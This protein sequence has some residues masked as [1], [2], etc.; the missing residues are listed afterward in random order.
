MDPRFELDPQALGISPPVPAPKT[1]AKTIKRP[2]RAVTESAAVSGGAK[3]TVHVVKSG[4]NLFRILMRDYGLTNEEAESFIEE[5]RHENNIYD[6]KRLKIGQKIIIPPI[7]RKADGT[8]KVQAAQR[9]ADIAP[10][11]AGQPFHLESPVAPLSE[12][13]AAVRMKQAWDTL[14]PPVKGSQDPIAIQS[15]TFSLSL[16]PARF[17]VYA[18]MN[19]RRILIDQHA[20]IP[21]LVSSLITEKDPSVRIVSE[22][23]A[24]GRHFIAAL[25]ESAGFYSVEENFTMEFGTDPKL[26]VQSDFKIEK[27]PESLIRHDVVLI[28]SGRVSYPPALSDFLKKEGFSVF[29]PFGSPGALRVDLPRQVFQITSKHQTDIVDAILSSLSVVS[30]KDRRLDVFAADNNGI[31]LSVKAERYFEQGGQST[32]VTRFDGDP[33]A[34]TLF[35]IL[36]ARGFQVVMLE[37]LDDFRKVSDKVLSRMRLKST[38]G[39]HKLNSDQAV[40]YSLLMSGIKLEGAGIPAGGIFLTNLEI[41]K[42]IRTLLTENGYNVT[43]K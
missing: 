27:T 39:Q 26:T 32:V 22:S 31:S 30:E 12:Q 28:N 34:Y 4:D 7:R 16:D 9:P 14:V 40:N 1:A 35:R 2:R 42:I 13:E 10:L 23:P 6:I 15:P 41:D 8:L 20:S 33:V 18:A 25:L 21:P 37:P 17:P 36:E 5:I 43:T 11:K 29:E 3:G 38:F 19:G 24:N